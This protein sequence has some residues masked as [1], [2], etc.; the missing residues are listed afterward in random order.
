ME[1]IIKTIVKTRAKWL[2]LAEIITT[3]IY[4]WLNAKILLW[5]SYA[6]SEPDHYRYMVMVAIGCL[7]NTLLLGIG[8]LTEVSTHIIFT[9]LNDIYADKVLD[10]DVKM[11]TKFPPGT[12]SHTGGNIWKFSKIANRA[13][14]MVRNA[15]S[16]A[17]NVIAIA[18]IAPNQLW[19][20][21][22]AFIFITLVIVKINNK[23]KK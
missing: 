15:L 5:I 9:Y 11:F 17:V 14:G 6:V 13:I 20:I 4:L 8:Q 18:T 16:V 7:V 21:G 22:G 3:T 1:Y 10:G 2:I 19:Q 12:I 23:W